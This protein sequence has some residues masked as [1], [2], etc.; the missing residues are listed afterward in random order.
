MKPDATIQTALTDA[1]REAGQND[2]LAQ[3]LLAWFTEVASGNES[4]GSPNSVSLRAELVYNATN[5]RVPLP[6]NSTACT[7][8]INNGN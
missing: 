7:E 6:S 8:E 1:V 2:S 4:L 3:K 5:H